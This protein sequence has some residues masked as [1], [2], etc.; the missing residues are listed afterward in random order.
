[1]RYEGDVYRPPSE[2]RSLII[3]VTIGCSHNRCTFCH[4]YADKQFRI[5]KKEEVMRDLDE[6]RAMYGPYVQRVFFADGDALIVPTDTLL[7]LL[8]YVHKNF[9]A[10]ERITSYGTAK[11]V[12]RKS[13]EE[14][15][16]L[17][18][19]GLE[20]IYLGA[21]SGDDAVL[22][23]ICKGETAAE[24]IAAGQRLKRC[25]M[26]TSVTLISGL[27]GRSGI[28]S[29]AEKSARLINAM[30]PEYAS[31]LTLHLSE[32]SPMAQEIARGEMELITPDEIVQ[33][34]EIFLR[35]IDSPGT[36]FRTNHAS[37]YVVLAGTFNEDIP[38]LLR[39]LEE[40]REK[41]RYRLEAWRRR[42]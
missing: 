7:E 39:Q 31:I 38:R 37:N 27:G 17:A 24:V 4:M 18:A 21:E 3:Q 29:H 15:R 41:Q 8:R 33:E 6:C 14:L 26:K 12:L 16:A 11:D 20:M 1:M 34:T 35:N 13:E 25:G 19:A 2:A 28:Q 9:P 42:L 36:V 10:V 32:E 30:N 23:H 5:R 22:T 40:A